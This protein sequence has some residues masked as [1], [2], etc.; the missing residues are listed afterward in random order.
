MECLIALLTMECILYIIPIIIMVI[1]G[2]L[3]A[4]VV[5]PFDPLFTE[6]RNQPPR[7]VQAFTAITTNNTIPEHSGMVATTLRETKTTP[8]A[9]TS[10][11]TMTLAPLTHA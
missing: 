10:T 11:M 9:T 6:G 8:I 2:M 1:P 5:A 4:T 7:Q 3:M